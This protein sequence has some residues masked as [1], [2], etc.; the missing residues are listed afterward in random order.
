MS[1]WQPIETADMEKRILVCFEYFEDN[2]KYIKITY[3]SDAEKG[4]DGL[5][6]SVRNGFVKVTHWMP[7]PELP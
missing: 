6:N 5:A 1:D 3:W 7:L 4:W 2:S